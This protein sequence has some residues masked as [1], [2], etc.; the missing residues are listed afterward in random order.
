MSYIIYT[1]EV[2]L[3]NDNE[4]NLTLPHNASAIEK[5]TYP[6]KEDDPRINSKI[7]R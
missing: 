7:R 4:K 6:T 5:K 1:D 2:A 3:S